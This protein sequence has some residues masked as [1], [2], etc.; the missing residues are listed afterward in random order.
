MLL[1]QARQNHLGQYARWL[2]WLSIPLL[3]MTGICALT[4]KRVL[5][6]QMAQLEA[7]PFVLIWLALWVLFSI[8][9][10]L[11]LGTWILIKRSRPEDL[12]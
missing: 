12:R 4:V 5:A 9:F 10:A 11:A 7:G 2:K 1:Q 6:G 8:C 3:V